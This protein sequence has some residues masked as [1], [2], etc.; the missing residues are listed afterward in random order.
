MVPLVTLS[1]VTDIMDRVNENTMVDT[2]DERQ[3]KKS[4]LSRSGPFDS[5]GGYGFCEKKIVQQKIE[6]K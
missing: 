1:D 5:W 4:G 3:P 2:D 6:N